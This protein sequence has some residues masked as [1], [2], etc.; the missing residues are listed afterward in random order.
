MV[1]TADEHVD[2][3]VATPAPKR[4]KIKTDLTVCLDDGEVEVHSII[5]MMASPVFEKMLSSHMQEGSG[6]HIRLP[7]KKMGEFIAFRNALQFCTMEP[8]TPETVIF[9]SCWAEEYQVG[10]LKAKCEDY[11]VSSVP[12]DGASLKHAIT[13]SMEKRTMTVPRRNDE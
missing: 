6:N 1:L 12:V 4:A 7:G 5:V 11:L 2:V 9:L 3:A 10:A 13:H 8:F